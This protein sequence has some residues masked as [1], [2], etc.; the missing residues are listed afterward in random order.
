MW[1][2]NKKKHKKILLVIFAWKIKTKFSLNI[3]TN[4]RVLDVI[5]SLFKRTFLNL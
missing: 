1:D 4:I 3:V 5:I 2:K